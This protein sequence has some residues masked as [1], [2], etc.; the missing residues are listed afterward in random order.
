MYEEMIFRSV[1]YGYLSLLLHCVCIQPIFFLYYRLPPL[2]LPVILGLSTMLMFISQFLSFLLPITS[3]PSLFIGRSLSSSILPPVSLPLA[4]FLFVFLCLYV[5][6]CVCGYAQ[7]KCVY[8][9]HK[10]THDHKTHTRTHNTRTNINKF[11][12]SLSTPTRADTKQT[13]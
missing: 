7:K 12:T 11:A 2:C 1:F 6:V 4:L 9:T 3:L 8:T 10:H 5:F 13:S